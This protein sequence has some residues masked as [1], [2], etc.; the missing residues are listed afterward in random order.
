MGSLTY[1]LMGLFWARASELALQLC[2]CSMLIGVLC[3]CLLALSLC[4][5]LLV[6]ISWGISISGLRLAQPAFQ[7]RF[8]L[9][10][11]DSACGAW[12][13]IKEL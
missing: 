5:W 8:L 6:S 10:H 12:L 4:L 11:L 2:A 7:S 3:A 9:F 1:R 13:L